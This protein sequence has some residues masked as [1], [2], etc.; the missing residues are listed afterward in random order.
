MASLGGGGEQ[1]F[2]HTC[3]YTADSSGFFFFFWSPSGEISAQ[4]K[5]KNKGPR[6]DSVLVFLCVWGGGG[7]WLGIFYFLFFGVVLC[8]LVLWCC[9]LVCFCG[10]FWPQQKTSCFPSLPPPRPPRPPPSPS[11]RVAATTLTCYR[12]YKCHDSLFLPPR[13][14]PPSAGAGALV[15]HIERLLTRVLV[16]VCL[17]KPE[18]E[19]TNERKKERK[20]EEERERERNRQR[21]FGSS[22]VGDQAG[23]LEVLGILEF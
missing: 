14:Q 18:K 20:K 23:G 8:A 10:C 9:C 2:I 19:T 11:K 12:C 17:G 6:W 22:F 16:C 21:C 7:G 1:P 15:V 4:E 13:H 3:C 5:Q